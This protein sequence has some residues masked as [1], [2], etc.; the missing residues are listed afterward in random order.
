M[1]RINNRCY[2]YIHMLY[3]HTYMCVCVCVYNVYANLI[4]IPLW[5]A[6]HLSENGYN[7][8]IMLKNINETNMPM[9]SNCLFNIIRNLCAIW[10]KSWG[11]NEIFDVRSEAKSAFWSELFVRSEARSFPEIVICVTL[12]KSDKNGRGYIP[13]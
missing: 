12:W 2:Y 8:L 3:I 6:Y 4:N 1:L 7:I 10:S 13:L 5:I 9:K 11:N